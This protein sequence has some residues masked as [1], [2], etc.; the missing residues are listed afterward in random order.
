MKNKLLLSVLTALIVISICSILIAVA[1]YWLRQQE[2]EKASIYMADDVAIGRFKPNLSK[3]RLVANGHKVLLKTNRYGIRD[4]TDL[5]PRAADII[6]L[7]DSNVAALYLP[8]K[9]TL[10][11]RIETELDNTVSVANLAVPG[12][13]P[14][15]AVN[16]FIQIAD[17]SNAKAVVLH[18]FADN[19]FGD[20]LRNNIYRQDVSGK[21]V[22]RLNLAREP[23]L[24]R[25]KYKIVQRTWDMFGLNNKQ[26]DRL[27]AGKSY[28]NPFAP[29][30]GGSVARSR[31]KNQLKNWRRASRLE[32]EYYLQGWHSAWLG[33]HYDYGISLEPHGDAARQAREILTYVLTQAA[34]FFKGKREC[35]VFLVQP[36]EDDLMD[37]GGT[38]VSRL[39][40]T[41][42]SE[43]YYP[44]GMVDL[45]LQAAKQAGVTAIDMFPVF[46][47]QPEEYYYPEW[48]RRGDG[49][50]N[51]RG[52][53]VAATRIA[54]HLRQ[55]GCL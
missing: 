21:W 29:R 38:S 5:Q 17:G 2:P 25:D 27:V 13:G 14:D 48:L 4:D 36:S 26:F 46:E 7:G 54:E 45:A 55:A 35:F 47:K 20:L 9:D 12:Y 52:I 1:E 34:K 41:Q 51:S 33:D 19:D 11:E 8:F 31:R 37:V 3:Y 18:F 43:Q 24:V 23:M 6:L 49:H 39:L 10:G 15:Q 16:R 44:R 22:M 30:M 50:W 32:Y 42:A 28:Y 40:L 53:N